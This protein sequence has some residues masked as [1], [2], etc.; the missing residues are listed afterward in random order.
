MPMEENKGNTQT[1]MMEH[2]D[3]IF[4]MAAIKAH[5]NQNVAVIDLPGTF[6]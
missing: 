6:L 2:L 3:S 1:K 5:K 4:I